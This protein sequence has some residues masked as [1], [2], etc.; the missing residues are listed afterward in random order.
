[1][2]LHFLLSLYNYPQTKIYAYSFVNIFIKELSYYKLI[3]N[4]GVNFGVNFDK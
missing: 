2:L 4:D 3:L 1:M